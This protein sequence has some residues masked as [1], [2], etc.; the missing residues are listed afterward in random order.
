MT[1]IEGETGGDEGFA[2]GLMEEALKDAERAVT[3]AAVH[4][5]SAVKRTLSGTRS[6]RMYR[7]PGTQVPHQAAAEG[8]PPAKM[9]GQLQ[10]AIQ[11]TATEVRGNEVSAAVGVSETRAA[12][13]YARIQELGGTI[14]HPNGAVIRIPPH[15]Y[16]RPTFDQEEARVDAI[17]KMAMP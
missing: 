4:L 6:G 7:V 2:E 13:A 16:L 17:L 15:P 1:P 8:E 12:A 10:Q 9:L 5:E 11:R 3:L 14:H